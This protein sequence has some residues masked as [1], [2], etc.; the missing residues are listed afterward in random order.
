MAE[1]VV[2]EAEKDRWD[3]ERIAVVKAMTP[4][5]E[6]VEVIV[7]ISMSYR[8]SIDHCSMRK[9]GIWF[10]DCTASRSDARSVH[11]C[12]PVSP[13]QF[14]KSSKKLQNR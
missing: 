1:Q 3:A 11:G 12:E 5:R 14:W 8:G 7:G 2:E 13:K 6:Y 9:I 10:Y 4:R